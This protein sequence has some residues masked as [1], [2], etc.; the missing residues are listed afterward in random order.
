VSRTHALLSSRAVE[1]I[2]S[3]QLA[4]DHEVHDDGEVV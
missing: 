2:N 4:R 1:V 3:L